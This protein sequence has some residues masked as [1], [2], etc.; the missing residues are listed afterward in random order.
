MAGPQFS[1]FNRSHNSFSGV[2]IKATFGGVVVAELQAI[3]YSITREK[4]PISL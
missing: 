4:A 1:E 2:D 3:S